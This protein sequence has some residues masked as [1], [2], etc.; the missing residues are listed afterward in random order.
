MKTEELQDVLRRIKIVEKQINLGDEGVT[1]YSQIEKMAVEA[2]RNTKWIAILKPLNAILCLAT[3]SAIFV[4]FFS[5]RRLVVGCM[6]IFLAVCWIGVMMKFAT[7]SGNLKYALRNYI[8]DFNDDFFRLV[9]FCDHHN[10]E[11]IFDEKVGASSKLVRLMVDI[12]DGAN[13]SRSIEEIGNALPAFTR[14]HILGN[15]PLQKAAD[16]AKALRTQ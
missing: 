16:L 10:P 13:V 9:F 7:V 5:E 11:K 12:Q 1:I 8:N 14:F 3:L 6:M 2:I 4:C 15:D